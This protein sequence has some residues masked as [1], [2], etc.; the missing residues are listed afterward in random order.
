MTFRQI[1]AQ[2]NPV[3]NK[4]SLNGLLAMIEK[5][6]GVFSPDMELDIKSIIVNEKVLDY[7][8]RII[9]EAHPVLEH[10][11]KKPAKNVLKTKEKKSPKTSNK[12]AI[13]SK[14]LSFSHDM[15]TRIEKGKSRGKWDLP[16]YVLRRLVKNGRDYSKESIASQAKN[17]RL[18]EREKFEANRVRMI[19]VPM[20][21]QNK[22]Y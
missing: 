9:H 21:G 5:N 16:D 2:Y 20:G 19:S 22:K 14:E 7:F 17:I 12:K 1:L 10:D 15:D 11:K 8:N 3:K 4:D 18:S 13:S 6:F